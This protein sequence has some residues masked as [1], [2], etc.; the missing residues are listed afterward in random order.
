MPKDSKYPLSWIRQFRF[1]IKTTTA[2]RIMPFREFLVFL[3]LI[4][5]SLKKHLHWFCFDLF[6]FGILV[7]FLGCFCCSLS[8]TR[9]NLYDFLEWHTEF[10]HSHAHENAKS[11]IYFILLVKC[12]NT[13]SEPLFVTRNFA[14]KETISNKTKRK[15]HGSTRSLVLTFRLCSDFRF[16]G[17]TYRDCIS[18]SR[19]WFEMENPNWK[20]H[21]YVLALSVIRSSVGVS[22]RLRSSFFLLLSLRFFNLMHVM[23]TVYAV[24][25][26]MCIVYVRSHDWFCT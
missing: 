12:I 23:F 24:G 14:G 20:S 2:Q 11:N 18:S 15:F 26:Y 7:C 17:Y 9:I 13:H 1:Q 21:K 6:S 3:A 25:T 4:E 5:H 16:I 8:K 22:M 10:S 19:G